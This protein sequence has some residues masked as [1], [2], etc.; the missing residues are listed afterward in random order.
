MKTALLTFSALVTIEAAAQDQ[1]LGGAANWA[2]FTL[3]NLVLVIVS[4]TFP[5][6]VHAGS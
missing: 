6:L 3:F 5:I 4:F 1:F 2:N